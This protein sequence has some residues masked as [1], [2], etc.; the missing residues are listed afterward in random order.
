MTDEIREAGES[1]SGARCSGCGTDLRLEPSEASPLVG[2]GGGGAALRAPSQESA[3]RCSNC[4]LPIA[5]SLR[6]ADKPKGEDEHAVLSHDVTC[7]KCGYNLRGL[8]RDGTCPECATAVALSARE[9]YL[10]F[11]EPGYVAKLARGNRWILRG[12]T[13]IVGCALLIM[14]GFVSVVPTVGG[15]SE[16]L[17]AVAERSMVLC[18]LGAVSGA[19]LFLFGLWAITSGE[20]TVYD[21]RRQDAARRLVR[22][23]LLIG[24]L[25]VFLGVVVPRLNPP[26]RVMAAFEILSLGFSVAGVVGIAAYF[27][28]LRGIAERF[29]DR[30]FAQRAGAL[31]RDL[32]VSFG[33]LVAF[34]ALNVVVRWGPALLPGGQSASP[35][36]S[37]SAPSPLGLLYAGPLSTVRTCAVGVA[38]LAAFLLSL[39]AIRLHSRLR[40]PLDQQAALA[41]RHW[42]A[43]AHVPSGATHE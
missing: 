10:C 40:K 7:R 3:E 35:V 17:V 30:Q 18:I 21:T 16:L 4:G 22:G 39:L 9:D 34:G 14:L 12:L 5:V 26:L 25:G 27:R 23:C 31:A 38:G 43:A 13:L 36:A 15:P 1:P 41:A 19:L 24:L 29:P 2:L 37:T 32:T 6:D 11:A 33:V 8:S 28:Y 42:S 20:P